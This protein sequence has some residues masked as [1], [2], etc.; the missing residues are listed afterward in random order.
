[1]L[2]ILFLLT[3]VLTLLNKHFHIFFLVFKLPSTSAAAKSLLSCPTLCSRIDGNP[4]GSPVPRILQARTLE[5]VSSASTLSLMISLSV[6]LKNKNNQK[7]TFINF[8]YNIAASI[9][10]Y[11]YSFLLLLITDHSKDQ[12]FL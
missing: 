1:M 7:I 4:P 9:T 8:Y 5:W 10:L 11:S 6:S 12:L 2:L 3:H